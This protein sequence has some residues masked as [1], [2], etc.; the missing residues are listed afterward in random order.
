M[1]TTTKVT[2]SSYIDWSAVI[3]GTIIAGAVSLLLAHF[4]GALGF[5]Y[6]EFTG[7]QAATKEE[8]WHHFLLLGLWTLWTQLM[9]SMA[10]GY[11]AGRARG[12]LIGNNNEA[13]IR[14]GAHG[15]L[16]WA[17]ASIF[18]A[19]TAA[20]G[21]FWATLDPTPAPEVINRLG[22]DT[23]ERMTLV[24]A[25]SLTIFSLVSAV[26]A[27]WMGTIGGDHRDRG[28]N[29]ADHISFRTQRKR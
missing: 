7:T 24:W 25:F 23:A 8:L 10:G 12:G 2:T 13:E 17:L 26:T 6:E 20:I 16:V 21:A 1:A 14:D 3:A 18:A 15:L 28:P 19:A 5:T 27:W 4:G 29:V 22:A 9:A 11:A